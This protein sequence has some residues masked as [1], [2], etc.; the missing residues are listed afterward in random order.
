MYTRS[1]TA[2]DS[3]FFLFGPRGTGKSLWVRSTFKESNYVDLLEAHTYNLLLVSPEKL[4]SLITDPGQWIIIDEIQKV[5]ALLDEVH[6]LI[7]Q[8]RFKFILT[9]SNSR[10][11]KRTGVNL[12]AGRALTKYLFP[13]TCKEIGHDFELHKALTY[14][15]LPIAYTSKT[16]KKFLKSYV[17]TYLREEILQESLVRNLASFARFLEAASFSQGQVLNVSSV[18]RDCAVDRKVVE[19]YF[20]ILEDLLLSIRISCF[21]K[22]AKRKVISHSKFYYFDVGVYQTLRPKGIL[23]TPQEIGSAALETLFLQ[24]LRALNSYLELNYEIYFWQTSNNVEVDFVI[25]GERGLKAF[26]IKR[27]DRVRS[28]EL[29]GLKLFL[30]DYPEARAYFLYFGEKEYLE[31]GIR[32]LPYEKVLR[33]LESFL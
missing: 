16:P 17:Q 18:A 13:L 8:M 3:S 2:E 28:D 7:E 23:D 14:G 1:I 26:E 20:T 32:I 12:L 9:G 30:S 27:A 5:P 29:K 4:S 22:R 21:T 6:R 31:D 24:E 10:K 11:L 19:D 25:Y 15:T 33:E